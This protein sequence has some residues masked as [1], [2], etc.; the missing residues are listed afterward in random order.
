MRPI[1]PVDKCGRV[2]IVGSVPLLH[3]EAQ[4]VQEMLE[5]WRSQQLCRN[6]DHETIAAEFG[7]SSGSWHSPTSS[8]G[9]GPRPWSR[10]FSDLRS[11]QGRKQSTVRGYQNAL[12]LCCE[13]VGGQFLDCAGRVAEVEAGH[14]DG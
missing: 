7:W 11:I 9:H 3:P 10:S 14:A 6:L 5:G 13:V 4:T 12:R 8:R 1:L 2:Y